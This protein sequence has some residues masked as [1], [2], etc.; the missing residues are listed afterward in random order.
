MYIYTIP[1]G[2]GMRDDVPTDGLVAVLAEAHAAR[3][4]HHLQYSAVRLGLGQSD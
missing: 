4:S 2:R 3:V 1:S